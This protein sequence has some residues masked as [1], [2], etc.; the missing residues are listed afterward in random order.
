MLKILAH[1]V[2]KFI[3]SLSFKLSFYA[4]LIMFLALLAFSYHTILT[5]ERNVIHRMIQGA[6]KDSDVIKAA[7]W[8]SM[9]TN[10][11]QLIRQIVKTIVREESIQEI[12]IYDR[13][14]QL[15]YTGRSGDASPV[16]TARTDP[17]I[18]DLVAANDVT[19]MFS[20]DGRTLSVA[21]PILNVA[22]CSTASCHAHPASDKS[23]GLLEVKLSLAGVK[24]EIA[25]SSRNTI[26]FA[27]L[28]FLL[29]STISGLAVVFL[30]NPGIK[31]LRRSAAKMARGD[32]HLGAPSNG[33][34]EIGKLERAFDEMS[35]QIEERT[36][37]LEA[38]RKMYKA[39][40][41]EV[42]CYLTVVSRDYRIVRANNAFRDTFGQ[43]V[44]K[45]CFAGYKGL[46]SKCVNCPVERTFRDGVTHQSEEIWEVN[47]TKVYVM[48]KTSPIV[49][50][51]GAVTE[52]LEMSIDV[53]RLKQLQIELE[54]KEKEYRYLFENAPCYLTV[55]DRD[56]NVIQTNKLFDDDFGEHVIRK[57][58]QIYKQK[59]F[60][61]S[62][63]PVER[64]FAD[65]QTHYSEET[66]R[67][68]GEDT[69]IIVYTAPIRDSSGYITSVMEM[70]TNITEVKRLQS[71]LAVL[72]ETIAGMSHTIKNILCGLQGGVYV[73]DS[74]LVRGKGERIR[75]GWEMV[76]KNVEKISELVQ[77][78][79]Y[80]S[81]EREPEYR[82]VDP[83]EL[84]TEIC[85]LYES[86]VRKDGIELIRA[87]DEKLGTC[88]LDPVGMH[89][90]LS[91]LV[92]NSLE[93]CA[94][95]DESVKKEIVVGGCMEHGHLFLQ[96]SDNGTGMPSE[97]RE[98]LFNRFYS[99][100]GS[101]GTGL[102]LV[103]TRKVVEEHGGVIQVD[104]AL[105]RGTTF[106]I[107]IPLRETDTDEALKTVVG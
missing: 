60:K 18:K 55:I 31:K 57:C 13:K 37:Q 43:Q 26:V 32:Y 34:D 62:N 105:G 4:S 20:P 77:G 22:S 40:F 48:V 44:G 7:I 97:V 61:C 58:Y 12:N 75:T 30:V 92:S 73:V 21:N 23:L 91:N 71:E 98:K 106:T 11:R 17:K 99:T 45:H 90:A 10:D 96:V 53:T 41:D 89:S 38:S 46:T 68:N 56:F 1:S 94:R 8:N 83:G 59:D 39:L 104:S 66:W 101:K 28:L 9:M 35:H 85:D 63:C 3:S 6:I 81:K 25:T 103:I 102:G 74:G 84:L 5:Q 24:K 14:G 16:R 51:N 29:I 2:R 49:D 72:G 70:S 19:H 80:A 65:G 107:E 76:K 52:V 54:K 82:E 79:L 42:P 47:G 100:K 86:R 88:L 69:H 87:F 27:V 67:R 33:S 93:A 64:T 15:R 50:E 95:Q 78:I 36:V